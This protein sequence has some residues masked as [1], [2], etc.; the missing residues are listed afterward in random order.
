MDNK[1]F[2]QMA[3]ALRSR[4]TELCGRFLSSAHVAEEPEDL[5]QETL[6]RLWRMGERMDAY[7]SVEA[8]AIMVAKNVCIDCLRQSRKT[9]AVADGMAIASEEADHSLLAGDME[10]M[11]DRAFSHLPPTQQRMLRW[12]S[13]GFGLDEI[14]AL[15]GT[16]KAS[17]KTLISAARRGMLK[18]MKGHI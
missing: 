8:L 7:R 5:V 15:C 1:E 3:M 4:L 17:V 2:E 12:R 18:Q 13:E 9:L 10:R 14:A 11:I 16:S 6:I